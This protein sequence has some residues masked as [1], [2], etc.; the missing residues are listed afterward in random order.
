MNNK[1]ELYLRYADDVFFIWKGTEEK[2]KQFF[3]EISKKH[4][5][6]KLDKKYSKLEIQFLDILVYKDEQQKLKTLFK[7]EADLHAKSDHPSSLKKV[8]VKRGYESS[9]IETKIK[10]IDLLDRKEFSIPKTT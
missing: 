6:I 1:V 8:S 7:E 3:N 5:L 10:K 9:S 4:T 2:L